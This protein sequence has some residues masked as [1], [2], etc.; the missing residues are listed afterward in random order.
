MMGQS[1]KRLT[2]C[3]VDSLTSRYNHNDPVTKNFQEQISLKCIKFLRFYQIISFWSIFSLR[4]LQET[5]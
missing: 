5:L 2:R 3:V 4:D 1:N